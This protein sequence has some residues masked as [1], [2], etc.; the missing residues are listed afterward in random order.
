MRVIY[1]NNCCLVCAKLQRI[2]G[3]HVL[4]KLDLFH[5][6]ARW[7]IRW[8]LQLQDQ[9]VLADKIHVLVDVIDNDVVK[10]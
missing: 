1:V 8:K 3:E 4:V 7:V 2:F 9:V 5:W 10:V 6:L